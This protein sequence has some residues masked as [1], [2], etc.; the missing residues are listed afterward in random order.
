MYVYKGDL[1][2]VSAA[3]GSMVVDRFIVVEDFAIGL[4][5]KVRDARVWQGGG[6]NL[7]MAAVDSRNL[8]HRVKDLEPLI[9]DVPSAG[10]GSVRCAG[11]DWPLWY[12]NDDWPNLLACPGAATAARRLGIAGTGIDETYVLHV[13]RI[14]GLPGY[15]IKLAAPMSADAVLRYEVALKVDSR[16]QTISDDEMERVYGHLSG[17]L[18]IVLENWYSF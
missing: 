3:G 17:Y 16:L 15:L 1:E 4:I 5:A 7:F 8:A 13:A 12:W 10:D 9:R 18:S 14:D 6:K 11:P 2:A